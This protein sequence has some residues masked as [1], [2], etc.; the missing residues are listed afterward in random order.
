MVSER[1]TRP[2]RRLRHGRKIQERFLGWETRSPRRRGGAEKKS[3]AYRGFTR[4]NADQ[5]ILTEKKHFTAEARRRPNLTTEARRHGGNPEFSEFCLLHI[6]RVL[7][8]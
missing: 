6:L 7:C 3:R 5:E 8:I 4:M 2:E 1:H